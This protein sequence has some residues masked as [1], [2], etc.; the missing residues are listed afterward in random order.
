VL[1]KQQK[2]KN[3]EEITFK[4]E[5]YESVVK[6]IKK[7]YTIV[8]AAGGLVLNRGEALMIWRLKKWDLP[9][10]KLKPGEKTKKAAIRGSTGGVQCKSTHRKEDLSYLAHL[11]AKWKTHF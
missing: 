4:V 1:L 8:K 2:P 11:Q 6:D 3:L 9:K 10:G 5:D 7:G